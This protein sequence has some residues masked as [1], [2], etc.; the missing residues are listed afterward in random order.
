MKFL[1][2]FYLLA[3]I[4]EF[5][6]LWR[7]YDDIDDS[8]YSLNEITDWFAS[9]QSK[10]SLAH[11]PG[12]WN[13]P[14]MLIIGNFGLSYGQSRAQMALWSI[15]AAPLIMSSDLRVIELRFQEILQN[16]N[17]ISINQD[18]L[19]IMGQQF[20]QKYN[21][22]E[23]WS[24]LLTNDYMAFVFYNP[25]PYGTPTNVKLSL[26]DLGLTKY[27]TYTFYESFSGNLIGQYNKKENFNTT[28]NPSGS[29]FAFWA[30]PA[31]KRIKPVVKS[32][33]SSRNNW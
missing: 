27:Q 30:E 22:V 16:K 9:Q 18:K 31:Q 19:G 17:L 8:F 4:S 33:V 32:S 11:G 2:F 26:K 23:V 5:C 7:N 24:K 1:I 6:N 14:D 28:V 21:G 15:M 12:H 25:L 20:K 10:L 29:V 3:R 13:D